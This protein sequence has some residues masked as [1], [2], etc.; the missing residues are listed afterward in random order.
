MS[1]KP[2]VGRPKKS[3]NLR[4]VQVSVY[5]T[6]EDA[7]FFRDFAEEHGF[8]SRSEVFTAIAERLVIG[9]MSGLAFVKLG[10]QFATLTEKVAKRTGR[11]RKMY[12]GVRPFP[13]LIGDDQDPETGK[14]VPF[15]EGIKKEVRKE[16]AA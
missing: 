16:N 9:G 15:L 4:N 2:K 7:E 11:Q 10:W 8:K 13:P 1:D 14:I 12:F 5:L 6:E 3:E